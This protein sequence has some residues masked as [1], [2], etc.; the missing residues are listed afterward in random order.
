M[1]NLL[2]LNMSPHVLQRYAVFS[3]N[4]TSLSWAKLYWCY[5]SNQETRKAWERDWPPPCDP[6]EWTPIDI[7]KHLPPSPE[8]WNWRN[9]TPHLYV[10]TSFDGKQH[11]TCVTSISDIFLFTKLWVCWYSMR[12]EN[13]HCPLYT[14]I[15]VDGVRWL[16]VKNYGAYN[17]VGG[18]PAP[19]HPTHTKQLKRL[20][21]LPAATLL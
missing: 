6:C 17:L 8:E 10:E 3:S 16:T 7:H 21:S 20:P 1:L 11:F 5:A 13:F 12:W 2:H 19:T 15:Q 4:L 18:C 9:E 14:D